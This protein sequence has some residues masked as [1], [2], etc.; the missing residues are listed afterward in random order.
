MNYW[1]Y[2]FHVF[3]V[4]NIDVECICEFD[5]REYH[6]DWKAAW[7]SKRELPTDFSHFKSIKLYII[8][9]LNW[10]IRKFSYDLWETKEQVRDRV[11][12]F[13]MMMQTFGY[14]VSVSD[15]AFINPLYDK[16]YKQLCIIRPEE[17]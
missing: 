7:V 5:D 9:Y 14:E 11:F 13:I 6:Q 1:K 17:N 15:P 8:V 10:D 16:L 2:D 12:D 3:S 4:K